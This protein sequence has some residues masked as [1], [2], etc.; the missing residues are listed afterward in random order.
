[1]AHSLAAA[2]ILQGY[3]EHMTLILVWMLV[4]TLI[5]VLILVFVL[6]LDLHPAQDPDP[7]PDPG[8]DHSSYPS[9]DPDPHS[10][11]FT[12]SDQKL[13]QPSESLLCH[14]ETLQHALCFWL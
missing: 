6:V 14:K 12:S 13:M 4:L 7:D 5:F 10:D 1:M 9:P 11:L 8:L 2:H 3:K